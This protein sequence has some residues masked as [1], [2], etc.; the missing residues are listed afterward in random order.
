MGNKVGP[1]LFTPNSSSWVQLFLSI[2]L[3]CHLLLW[4]LLWWFP[5]SS[6]LLS[7]CGNLHSKPFRF[8]FA[9]CYLGLCCHRP[10]QLHPGLPLSSHSGPEGWERPRKGLALVAEGRRKLVSQSKGP[11]RFC[12]IPLYIACPLS[13]LL[14][15]FLSVLWIRSAGHREDQNSKP[16]WNQKP[17]WY[18][19]LR[20]LELR[21]PWR[22][23]SLVPL[24]HRWEHR[25]A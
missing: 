1:A 17:H 24:S 15:S 18:L 20:C 16:S 21:G 6:S 2:S 9:G 3:F 5:A 25:E 8:I 22:P 4:P 10:A 19:E 13:S 23:L 12:R 7:G 14:S 11:Q